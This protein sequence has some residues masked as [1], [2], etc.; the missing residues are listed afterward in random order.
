[1]SIKRIYSKQMA[2]YLRKHG[3]EIVGTDVNENKP[4][5]D[6]WLFE[7]SPE[8]GPVMATFKRWKQSELRDE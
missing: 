3:F 1:M 8:M 2:I 7:D 6:V 4:E 5:F